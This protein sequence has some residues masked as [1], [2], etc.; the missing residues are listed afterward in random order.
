MSWISQKRAMYE[1]ATNVIINFITVPLLWYFFII[2]ITGIDLPHSANIFVIVTLT[3]VSVLRQ[4]TVR[5]YF[6]KRYHK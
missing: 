3:T 6:H 4:Y 5:R 1:A 2:P